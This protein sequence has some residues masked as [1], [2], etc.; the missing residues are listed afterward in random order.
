MVRL[1]NEQQITGLA[2]GESE[3]DTAFNFAQRALSLEQTHAALVDAGLEGCSIRSLVLESYNPRFLVDVARGTPL[4]DEWGIHQLSVISP[5]D[6]MG[7]RVDDGV[8]ATEREDPR[9]V[10]IA[11]VGADGKLTKV[12]PAT[13][14]DQIQRF[15]SDDP[16]HAVEWI[17]RLLR[18]PRPKPKPKPKPDATRV[19][20][21]EAVKPDAS[22]ALPFGWGD[23]LLVDGLR[24]RTDLNRR[25]AEAHGRVKRGETPAREGITMLLDGEEVWAR[26]T[27][28]R[29]VVPS[30]GSAEDLERRVARLRSE[31]DAHGVSDVEVERAVRL[32]NGER[33]VHSPADA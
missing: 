2:L 13:D 23:I 8:N 31:C 30:A 15:P 24:R 19:K 5:G 14:G 4:R 32:L 33:T 1:T 11:T 21:L 7:N 28:L 20:V 10:E 12:H 9:V 17:G 6:A 29:L 16:T 25:L 27:D 22:G 26:R 3:A 18:E